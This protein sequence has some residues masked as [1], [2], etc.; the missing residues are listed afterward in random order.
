MT[1]P[2]SVPRK[3][4]IVTGGSRGIGRV[5]TAVLV[6]A[7]YDVRFTYR[8]SGEE[9]RSLEA[10]LPG[11]VRG[12]SV[13]GTDAG[14]V[15]T[16]VGMV[17]DE[18]DIALLVNN[19]GVTKDNLV[20]RIGADEVRSVIDNNLC[21]TVHFCRSVLPRMR[22]ARF[23][24]IVNISSLASG[25]VRPGNALYGASKAAVERFTQSLAIECARS[26]IAVNTVAPG[27]VETEL[28]ASF[29]DGQARRDLLARIPLR[30]L[31]TAREVAEAVLLLA[32]RRPL[33][34]GVTLPVGGGGH[35]IT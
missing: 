15:S 22:R 29:L 1:D 14:A 2:E 20:D 7:G 19:A 26:N 5:I 33:L 8:T 11:R 16:F 21:A 25:N 32:A 10:E 9:A 23:G 28:T 4:A 34:I 3:L 35:I 12:S 18:G 13:D 27:F 24:D 6:E 31:T 30:H 17:Q